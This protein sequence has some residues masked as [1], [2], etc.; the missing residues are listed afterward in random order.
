M[1]RR[2]AVGLALLLL[3]ATAIRLAWFTGL[4]VGDDIVYSKI[5]AERLEGTLRFTNIHE[6]RLGFLLPLM[7]GYA[8]FG[9]GEGPLVLYNLICSVAL[10][11]V[12]FALARRFWGERAGFGA[13]WIAILYPQFVRF[14]TECHADTPV[15][16][17]QALSVLLFLEAE[18]AR[19]PGSRLVL[20]GLVL[21]W[22]HLHKEHAVFLI[23]FF[24]VHAWRTGRRWR[25]YLPLAIPILGA[26]LAEFAGFWILTGSPFRRWEMIRYWH[27][28]RYMA[29][30]YATL[31]AV[32][33][34]L[35][36]D[37]PL[38]LLAPW[39]GL[40]V[41]PAL[42]AGVGWVRKGDQGARRMA[43]WWI[44]IYLGYSF[45]PS[46]LVPFRPCF[47][48]FEWTLPVL[49]AP[50]V[51]LLGAFL[52]RVRRKPAGIAF[53]ALSFLHGAILHG[54]WRHER[55]YAVGAR[56][57]VRW[58]REAQP[59][60]VIADD[61]TVEA[62]DFFE[63]H[64]PARQYLTFQEVVDW[65]GSIVIVD[66]FWTRPGGRFSRP[67]PPQVLNPP[68]GWIRVYEGRRITIYRT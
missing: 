9:P 14:A 46:S 19:S 67:V 50:L 53:L 65:E 4:Q 41:L 55:R 32:L 29:E 60:R 61:K 25:W 58:I 15:A 10:V 7:A 40:I 54:V 38:R 23:P 49:G 8:L 59:S 5:A 42:M 39:H 33:Y 57:A 68:P 64:R 34:R 48:L 16:L 31:P 18:E 2:T 66:R 62:L 20:A 45:A 27:S 51:I 22:A 43:G 17:W 52:S 12:I 56:E 6:T 13:A 21:G 28:G 47:Y 30:Y 11:G 26:V 35:F 1:P 37:L 44:S 63:A 24:A 36:L 3:L